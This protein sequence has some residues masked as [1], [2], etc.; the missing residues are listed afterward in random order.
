V[1]EQHGRLDG[2]PGQILRLA[3]PALGV[4][5][6][7]PVYLL[8]DTAVVGRLGT[9]PL[10]GLAIGSLVLTQVGTQLT[11]LTYGTTARAARWF[12][13][14]DRPAAVREGVQATWLAVGIGTLVLVVMQVLARPV[15]AAL[16]GSPAIADQSLRW[17]RIALCGAPLILIGLAG[18]GWLRGVRSATRPL[19][20]AV[21]G[22]LV[23]GVLCVLLV[24]GL[25][26]APRMGLAG[27][28]VANV[29]GQIVTAAL[30]LTALAAE[31]GALAPQPAVLAAQLRAGRD[32]VL[33]SLAFQACFLSAGAVAA[34]FGAAAV[35]AHQL[36]VQL[37]GLLANVLDS[38]AIAAQAL[39][40]AALGADRPA[41][42]TG[43][44]WRI[45]RWSAVFA[46]L[47]AAVCAV[48]HTLIPRLFTT[49]PDVLAQAAVV[50]WFL[51]ALIPLGGVVFALDGVLLGAGDAAFLRTAT[52]TAALVGFLPAIWLS[53][54]CGWG[55]AGIWTGLLLFVLV[56]LAA[57]ASRTRSGKWLVT[58]VA[59]ASVSNREG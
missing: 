14:G 34:R 27:S 58:G 36:A 37:W 29:V 4:L 56:R 33:R 30:F 55:L 48:G 10:A 3:V 44:A 57:V 15:V 28:A 2:G 52:L 46:L 41:L 7:E 54:A 24:H 25:L 16:A 5:S 59:P 21:C 8:L 1:A 40:G 11:F 31:R 26:G 13:A 53:L 19:L 45:T 39:V 50:W 18:N 35:G 49:A 43:L 32:L 20:F 17:L 22:L 12:G 47:L 51:V 42:A 38:L 23:S 6:A 9:L